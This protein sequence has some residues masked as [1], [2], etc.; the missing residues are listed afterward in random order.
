MATVMENNRAAQDE[1]LS[2]LA[3]IYGDDFFALDNITYAVSIRFGPSDAERLLFKFFL[4]DSYP[5]SDAPVYTLEAP[6]LDDDLCF[7]ISVG[8][9]NNRIQREVCLYQWIEWLRENLPKLAHVSAPQERAHLQTHVETVVLESKFAAEQSSPSKS[10]TVPRKCPPIIRGEPM[11]DRK[12]K[13]CDRA[14]QDWMLVSLFF[15]G[16][17]CQLHNELHVTYQLLGFP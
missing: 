14:P 12:S 8:L 11:T 3:S 5:S 15:D 4:P 13:V 6:W 10:S 16:D 17:T 9:D 1:E 2:A 7:Q